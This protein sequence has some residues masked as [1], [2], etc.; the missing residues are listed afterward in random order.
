VKTPANP[1]L[2]PVARVN[3]VVLT[4]AQ[5]DREIQRLFPYFTIHGGHLPTGTEAELRKKAEHDLVL[6]ELVYQEA[7]RRGLQVPPATWQKR[8]SAVRQQVPSRSAFQAAAKREYGSVPEFEHQLRRVILIEQLL[9]AEVNRKSLVTPEMVRAYY[10]SRKAQFVRPEAVQ[11][12]TITIKIPPNATAEQKQQARK[13]AEQILV[14]AKAAKTYEEFGMLAQELSED[15]WRVM[16]GDHRWVHRGAV[17]P[18]LEETLFKMRAGETS[19]VLSTA[20]GYL[21]LRA[22]GYQT[23]QQMPL[24]KVSSSIRQH[25]QQEKREK[26]A[27]EFEQLLRSKAKIQI[28]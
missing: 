7:R 15:N 8:L 2:T 26:R 4:E 27:E 13:I 20:T 28:L 11:L 10:V 25:L 14:K 3:D 23:K 18:D 21:I 19:E 16:M 6:H 24:A 9:D 22:N 5:L 17:T 12:Q 1:P